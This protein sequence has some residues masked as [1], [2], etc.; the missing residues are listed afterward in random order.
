MLPNEIFQSFI[1][2]SVL[3]FCLLVPLKAPKLELQMVVSHYVG[4]RN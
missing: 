1:Y 2:L 3:V 4:A